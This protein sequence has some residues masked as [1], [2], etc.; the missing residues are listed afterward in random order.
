[1]LR[2][3]IILLL[4]LVLIVFF[5]TCNNVSEKKINCEF[6]SQNKTNIDLSNLNEACDFADLISSISNRLIIM[7]NVKTLSNPFLNDELN[8]SPDQTKDE[9]NSIKEEWKCLRRMFNEVGYNALNR[10]IRFL[11]ISKCI[12]DFSDLEKRLKDH[13]IY[14]FASWRTRERE[15][16]R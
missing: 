10:D 12:D 11:E 1:M 3:L 5:S 15:S 2:Y 16:L 7:D 6:I 8:W 14:F 13:D 4:P 9:R